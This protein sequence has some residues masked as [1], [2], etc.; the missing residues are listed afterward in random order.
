MAPAASSQEMPWMDAQ[1]TSMSKSSAAFV[2]GDPG[3]AA[4][5]A[6][7]EQPGDETLGDPA[8]RA[9]LVD[10]EHPPG[11]ATLAKHILDRQRR[12][13]AQVDD[14]D[15]DALG[16]QRHGYPQGHAQPV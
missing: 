1:E 14:P 11:C 6:G 9:R 3:E 5:E 7:L 15:A 16:A 13:P 12:E 8:G 4:V 10:D 2:A